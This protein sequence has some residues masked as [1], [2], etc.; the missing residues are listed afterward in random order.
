MNKVIL[1]GNIG[2]KPELSVVGDTIKTT[3]RM[4]TKYTDN[5]KNKVTAWHFVT[6]WGKQAHLC[7][8]FLEPGS[9][10]CVEGFI[11]NNQW[12]EDD[13]KNRY[14]VEIVAQHVEFLGSSKHGTQEENGAEG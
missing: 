2:R 12:V 5:K 14:V 8:Q 6:V 13:G 9:R 1:A 7:C 10:V 3:L 4:A 11:K